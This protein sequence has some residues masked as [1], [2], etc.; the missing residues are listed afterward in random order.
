[1]SNV[2]SIR[3]AWKDTSFTVFPITDFPEVTDAF[4]AWR[5][6]VKLPTFPKIVIPKLQNLN[7]AWFNCAKMTSIALIDT[8]RIQKLVNTFG[9]CSLLNSIPEFDF[10][11]ALDIQSCFQRT[12]VQTIPH[13][14][15]AFPKLEY[16]WFAFYKSAFKTLPSVTFP[17]LK[18]AKGM[19]D[20]CTIFETIPANVFNTTGT[21]DSDC[22]QDTFHDCNLT[23][24]SIKNL[25]VS[26][27]TNGQSN[28]VLNI[29]G[30]G[31]AAKSTWTA[32][33]NTAYDNL[34]AKGWTIIYNS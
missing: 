30:G 27:D 7:E 28:V 9:Y 24:T 8:S 19:F 29:D 14:G 13:T 32:A 25:L 1:M 33:T 31:N 3:G 15:N 12:S 34:I 10:G 18:Q 16:S 23:E 4:Q 17:S 6:C 11:E 21:L 5:D 22:F 2:T 20:G 26:L